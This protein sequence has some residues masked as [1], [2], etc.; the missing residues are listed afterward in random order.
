[1]RKH[2][3]SKNVVIMKNYYP[4]DKDPRVTK[5][6]TILE[7]NN[8]NITYLGWE[9]RT[10]S[11]FSYKQRNIGKHKEIIMYAKPPL[12]S[13]FLLFPLWWI[14]GLVWL[15][16]LN[17]KVVHVINF[18]SIFPAI[19]AA[20]I[21]NGLVV[22]D[23]EDTYIDQMPT[24]VVRLRKFGLM[25]DKIAMRLTDAVVLVDE[26]QVEEFEGIPSPKVVVVYDAPLPVPQS[27]N[28]MNENR[29]FTIFYAGRIG[30]GRRLNLESLMDAIKTI[31]GVKLVI[32]GDGEKELVNKIKSAAL[33][34]PNKVLYLGWLPYNDVLK[35]SYKVDLLFS[36]RDPN[37]P[38]QKYICGS[39]FLEAIMCGKPILVNKDTSTAYKVAEA[40]CGVVVDSNNVEEIR[41]AILQLIHDKKL[42]KMFGN[43]GLKAYE[44]KYSWKIMSQ[45]LLMLYFELTK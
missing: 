36:L 28:G 17:W 45:R 2:E 7:S 8:Y 18:P 44:H 6:I 29:N 4:I 3:D 10:S 38:A 43:N 5:V 31:E 13:T 19:F 22:Y 11:L 16:R 25:I 37:P 27:E 20:P 9:T 12:G 21:K 15:L 24:E 32:A 35:M 26:M 40:N 1:M 23:I 34:M 33:E 42:C 30:K 41:T 39:K 14:F